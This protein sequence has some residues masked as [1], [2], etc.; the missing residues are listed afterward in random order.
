MGRKD[1]AERDYFN[2]EHRFAENKRQKTGNCLRFCRVRVIRKAWIS[3]YPGK[4]ADTVN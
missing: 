4:R 2:D 3:Y 1:Y